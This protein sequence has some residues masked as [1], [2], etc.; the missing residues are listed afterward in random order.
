MSRRSPASAGGAPAGRG[1]RQLPQAARQSIDTAAER[2]DADTADRFT[3]VSRA[4]DKP[5]WF[6]EAHLQANA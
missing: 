1:D 4:V 5:L 6:V 3:G 2:R